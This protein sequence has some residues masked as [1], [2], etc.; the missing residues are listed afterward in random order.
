LFDR[1]CWEAWL[2][3]GGRDIS[4]EARR[5]AKWILKEHKVEPIEK[6]VQAKLDGLIKK[7]T[8]ER[9]DSAPIAS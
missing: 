3:A 4:Q 5:K 7:I 1:R 9:L 6:G 8:K 2:K